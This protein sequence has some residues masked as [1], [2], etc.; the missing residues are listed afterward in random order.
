MGKYNYGNK[1]NF[2][3]DDDGLA[4]NYLTFKFTIQIFEVIKAM[5]ETNIDL[6][7]NIIQEM[8]SV[9][10]TATIFADLENEDWFKVQ[11]GLELLIAISILENINYDDNFIETWV[12]MAVEDNQITIGDRASVLNELVTNE[13]FKISE[14][15][16][17]ES[18]FELIEQVSLQQTLSS[19]TDISAE[20][21]AQITDN[22]TRF[23]VSD[24][25]IG[26]SEGLDERYK[27]LV[28]FDMIIDKN[29]SSIQVM[30][31]T[32]KEM[33]SLPTVDGTI[34][35]NTIYQNRLFNIVAYSQDGMDEEQQEAM[36]Q[37]ITKLLDATKNDTKT[38]TFGAS[39]TTFEVSYE[40]E[41]DIHTVGSS[42]YAQIPFASQPYGKKSFSEI[43]YGEGIINND[44]DT[45]LGVKVEI[46]SG[47]VN[48]N[49]KI[50]DT[51]FYWSGT[52]PSGKT[53]VIDNEDTTCYLIDEWEVQTQALDS[54]TKGSEFIV[55]A[56]GEQST[57]VAL[58]DS[59]KNS[60]KIEYSPLILWYGKRE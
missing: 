29:K 52:V 28:P 41:A 10:D 58:N 50:D 24:F 16:S 59:T 19:E 5:D 9:E 47:C 25:Y 32:E 14:S 34:T 21:R 3:L 37:K 55:T 45:A 4:Y 44:G 60:L 51:E 11:E 18:L 49:F 35:Q 17:I 31:A 36:L 20:E 1:Y 33:I 22:D 6:V 43:I 27:W 40:G 12:E 26:Q 48:P 30:P 15:I 42:V 54:L 2:N 7:Q 39:D 38:L 56:K 46:S 53:L 13:D 57:V 8:V 23:T